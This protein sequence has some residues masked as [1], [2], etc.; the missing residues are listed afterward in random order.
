[1]RNQLGFTLL[2]LLIAA[3][4]ISVLAMFATRAFRQANSDI[5][6]QDAQARAKIVA[7]AA[8]RMKVEYPGVKFSTDEMGVVSSPNPRHCS[9]SA[10]V[11]LQVLIDCGY[12]EYRQYAVE[13]R[14]EEETDESKAY[15]TNFNMF[16]EDEESYTVCVKGKTSKITDE[17]CFCTDGETLDAPKA[18]E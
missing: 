18:C 7:M 3:A 9:P 1:M 15:Q 10:T 16:F 4:I 13:A 11:N 8:H 6:I 12:L 2:E 5:R 14:D 17:R